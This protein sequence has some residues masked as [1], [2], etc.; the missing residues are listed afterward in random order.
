[1]D[2]HV[3]ARFADQVRRAE[4]VLFTGAGF[5]GAA[6]NASGSPI[7]SVADLKQIL[8]DCAFPG[9]AFDP[10]SSLGDLFDCAVDQAGNRTKRELE[11]A[12]Q[13]QRDSLPDGYAV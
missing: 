2:D 11:A 8:W 12:L 7:P 5:S 13:V 1:M 10:G 9:E 3:R 6:K 4:V